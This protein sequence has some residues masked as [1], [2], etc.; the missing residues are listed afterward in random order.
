VIALVLWMA[1][2]I[3]VMQKWAERREH[4]RK[5]DKER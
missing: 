2:G 1:I 4:D 3:L 5:T